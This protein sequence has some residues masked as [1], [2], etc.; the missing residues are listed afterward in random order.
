MTFSN[1]RFP[2]DVLLEHA[3]RGLP[4]DRWS[5]L[6]EAA[7]ELGLLHA[8]QY[9]DSVGH[10]LDHQ[11][12][13]L[14][15]TIDAVTAALAPAPQLGAHMRVESVGAVVDQIA[16][17][18]AIAFLLP[19]GCVSPAEADDTLAQLRQLCIEYTNLLD[20]VCAGTCLLPAPPR[21]CGRLSNRWVRSHRTSDLRFHM[22]RNDR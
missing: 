15:Q 7:A 14:I 22:R 9:T 11:R 13:R 10:K 16:A 2:D 19:P 17:C 8:S 1:Q 6:L 4:L 18:S 21:H 12:L 20:E 3:C 5:P